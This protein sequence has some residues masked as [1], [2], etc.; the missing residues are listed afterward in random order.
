MAFTRLRIVRGLQA[1]PAFG[2]FNAAI[3][4]RFRRLL[5]RA[6]EFVRNGAQAVLL[7]DIRHQP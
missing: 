5:Q 6:Q 7:P 1:E 4:L 2:A 3:H